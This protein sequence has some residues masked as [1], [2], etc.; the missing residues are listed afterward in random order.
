MRI[1]LI[2]PPGGGKGTQGSLINKEYNILQISTGDLLRDHKRRRTAI[3]KQARFYMDSGELVPDR[4]INGMLIK[5][6]AKN[7][8]SSGFL[9]DGYPRTIEQA[10]ELDNVLLQLNNKIDAVIILDVSQDELIN[11]LS[12]RR[13]CSICGKVYHLVFNPPQMELNCDEPCNGTLFQRDDDRP[14]TIL[15][16][17]KVYESK[18]TSLISYYESLGISY[19]INGVGKVQTV[20]N[21][22]KTI[23]DNFK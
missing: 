21:N 3:G 4:L 5:E 10:Y 6:L 22:I 2:A 7:K 9:L 23:L 14:D 15:K 1:I 20:Y 16:R 13:V 12:A 11:R 17:L 19:K 18:T 8:Y